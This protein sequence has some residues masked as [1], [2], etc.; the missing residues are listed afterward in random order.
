VAIKETSPLLVQF[1]PPFPARVVLVGASVGLATPIFGLAGVF[2]MYTS[3]LPKTIEGRLVKAFV[4]LVIGGGTAKLIFDYAIPFLYNNSNLIAPF[5]LANTVTSMFWYTV[6]EFVF[7]LEFLSSKVP[8]SFLQPYLANLR[9][10]S[11]IAPAVAAGPGIAGPVIGAL[12]AL[13]SP[14]LWSLAIDTCW[15]PELKALVQFTRTEH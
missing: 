8:L 9:G 2:R 10:V 12:T 15:S 13:T 4:G 14:F 5:A 3:Y 7:G 6:G 1:R 11:I